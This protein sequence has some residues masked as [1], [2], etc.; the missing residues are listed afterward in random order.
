VLPHLAEV[1]EPTI[2]VG[3]LPQHQIVNVGTRQ[4]PRTL[5]RDDLLDLFQTEAK[6]LRL[7]DER[8]Q[9]QSIS[10]VHAV[11]RVGPPRRWED[12]RLLVQPQRLPAGAR[13]LRHLTDQEPLSG[14]GHTVDP[15]PGG[16]V[17][18]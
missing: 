6:P 7:P 4:T 14:H 15:A 13:L 5:D 11:A 16:K 12:A 17:K 9:V 8:Q 2:E 18:R 1:C 10:A 3:A